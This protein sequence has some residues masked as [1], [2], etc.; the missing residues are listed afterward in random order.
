MA[1]YT[2]AVCRK[3]RREHMKLYLKGEKCFSAKCTLEKRN[4]EP[5][6][7]GGA[8]AAQKT[9]GGGKKKLS[10]YGVQ[11]REKQKAR[12]IYG[13]LERQF[14][15]NF[16]SAVTQKGVTGE[17]LIRILERRLDNVIYR[18]G[19][20]ASRAAA[21]QLVLHGHVRV[22]G[23]RVNIP[24]FSVKIGDEI[25]LKKPDLHL[26][27]ASVENAKK[28]SQPEWL[29]V[30]MEKR[31]GKV[32]SLPTRDALEIPLQEKLIVELYSK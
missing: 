4:Y 16:G 17:N 32:V 28:R 14:R 24:S 3:C 29:S 22:S 26:V 20:A 23:R 18:M 8:K 6:M 11:L 5:G 15:K 7:A 21:R 2:E 1:R 25:T 12:G 31:T 27:K 19:F 13:I 10:E 30:D 9:G